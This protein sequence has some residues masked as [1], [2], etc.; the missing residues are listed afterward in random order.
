MTPAWGLLVRV[1]GPWFATAGEP[2]HTALLDAVIDWCE[3]TGYGAGGGCGPTG[4]RLGI[5]PRR[6]RSRRS[7]TRLATDAAALHA[8]IAG[9]LATHGDTDATITVQVVD[10]DRDDLVTDD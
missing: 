2:A 10:L 6:S 9:H 7:R 8:L 4:L 1:R 3:A 5:E